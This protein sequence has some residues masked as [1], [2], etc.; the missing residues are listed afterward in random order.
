M[1]AEDGTSWIY[2]SGDVFLTPKTRRFLQTYLVGDETSL[3]YISYWSI[4]HLISGVLFAL[5]VGP[6]RTD[7]ALLGFFVHTCWEA[8]QILIGMS[9]VATARGF[10]DLIVDTVMFMFGVW[11]V[12]KFFDQ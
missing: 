9:P 11:M 10:V 1:P 8:W 3:L 5:L 12:A 6:R 7:I 2:R 4:L